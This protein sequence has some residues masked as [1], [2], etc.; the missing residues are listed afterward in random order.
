MKS[1]KKGKKSKKGEALKS[2]N[3]GGARDGGN[4]HHSSATIIWHTLP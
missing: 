1:L 3:G 2:Y 4:N